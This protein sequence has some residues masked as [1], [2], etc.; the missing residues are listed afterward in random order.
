MATYHKGQELRH[1]SEP[2]WPTI[3]IASVHEDPSA[4]F[5]GKRLAPFAWGVWQDG[6]GSSAFTLTTLD[7]DWEDTGV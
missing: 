1:K 4:T 7:K 5:G 2:T 3:I 6:G